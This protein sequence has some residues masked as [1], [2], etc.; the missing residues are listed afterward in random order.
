MFCYE[1]QSA[2]NSP[3]YSTSGSTNTEIDVFSIKA[4]ARNASV[5][6]LRGQ[7]RGAGLTQL[8]GISLNVKLWTTGSTAGTTLTPSPSDKASQAATAVPRI[9]TGGGV[10]AVTPGSGGPTYRGGFGFSG[11]GPGGWTA[12]NPDAA[13]LLPGSDGG[14]YDLYSI[15]GTASML[16]EFWLEHS[17]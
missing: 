7:G 3:T 8:S 14:S 5:Y 13:I 15:S 17:E 12:A 9:G 2:M 10:N 4:G 6:A 16:Y 11:S 1:T